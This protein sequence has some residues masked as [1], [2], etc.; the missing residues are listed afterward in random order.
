MR[1]TALGRS[2]VRVS[3]VCLGCMGL[4]NPTTGQ[5]CWTVGED[6]SRE[7]I[8]SALDSGINFFDT[9]IGYQDGTSEQYLGRALRDMVDRDEVVVATKFL[10]RSQGEID[11]SIGGREHVL[12]SLDS[13]LA[14]LGMDHVDLLIYHMWDHRTPLSEIME[15]LKEAMDSGKASHI[16]I[17]N[18]FAWQLCRANAMADAMDMER[19]VS[20]QNHYNLV[21]REEEREMAPYCR[22]AGIAMT[23]YSPLAG[24][25][26]SRPPG[27]ETRRFRE[28]SYAHLKYDAAERQDRE[29][30]ER[31]R[32]VAE[33]HGVSM[34]QV[35][36]AWLL[37]RVDSPVA[38]ATSPT[39]VS[40]TADAADLV[41][42]D[43][44]ILW[45]EEPYTPHRLVGVMAQNTAESADLEHVWSRKVRG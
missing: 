37:T 31:V 9:A 6:G 27:E 38:G 29:I 36:I 20:V 43:S 33:D 5:H 41:L 15:G 12:R 25:R 44:E 10:P 45:L 34:A 4:G 22:W 17:S 18:C 1:Y 13:S 21:F 2:G 23:P 7:V 39:Q 14:H 30:V 32:K 16:G 42:S 19:F 24:G 8:R 35:S 11:S 28:D 3:R 26:L 40:D